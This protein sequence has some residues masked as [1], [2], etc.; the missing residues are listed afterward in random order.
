MVNAI[1]CYERCSLKKSAKKMSTSLP[2]IPLKRLSKE[3]RNALRVSLLNKSQKTALGQIAA[4]LVDQ[5]SEIRRLRKQ[6]KVLQAPRG[7][8]VMAKMV[9]TQLTEAEARAIDY[10]GTALKTDAA[11]QQGIQIRCLIAERA[12]LFEAPAKAIARDLRRLALDEW[13]QLEA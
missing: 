7:D 8:R 2:K 9:Q 11:T 13:L 3:E 10:L 4:K 6:L 5:E 12:D 1:A